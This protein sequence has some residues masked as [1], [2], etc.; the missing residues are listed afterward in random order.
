MTVWLLSY[1][2]CV[3]VGG[4]LQIQASDRTQ[5]NENE[6]KLQFTAIKVWNWEQREKQQM[7]TF[8]RLEVGNI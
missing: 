6:I 3:V 2:F 7:L 1:S 5:L 8:E 4:S